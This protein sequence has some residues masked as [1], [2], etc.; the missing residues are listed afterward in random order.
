MTYCIKTP[1]AALTVAM[2]LTGA[3]AAMA[4]PTGLW[5][6]EPDRKGQTAHV[7][8]QPCDSGFCGTIVDVFG[9]NGQEVDAPTVGTRV[10]W[11]MTP[12]GG[13][14]YE[15]RA[16]VPAHDRSYR[17]Q[18]ELM[19]SRMEVSGCLGPICQSQ[20]WTRVR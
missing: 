3:S 12:E 9:P 2:S 17:A 11:N 6:T 13:G 1:L 19:G 18:M 8:A 20:T 5:K 4:N 16:Y 14:T 10:F 15:G 7:R